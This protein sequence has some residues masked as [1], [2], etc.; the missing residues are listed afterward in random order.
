MTKHR[1]R[2]LRKRCG[3][4]RKNW[5]KCPHPWHFN[6]K[7]NGE[8]YR[9]S[10]DREVGHP[11]TSKTDA[12]KEADRIR[13]AIRE[14][15]FRQQHVVELVARSADTLTF[16]QFAE[17]WKA[18]RGGE[19]VRPKDNDYRIEKVKAF[20]LSGP[21]PTAFGDKPLSSITTDDI[22]AFRES[23]KA[24]GLSAVTVNHDLKLLRK[25]FNWGIR[26]GYMERTPFKVGSESAITLQREIPRDWRFESEDDEPKLL[27]AANP[28]LR[29][30]LIALLDTAARLGEILSLQWKDVNLERRELVIRA[31]SRRPG[32]GALCRFRLDSW[33]CWR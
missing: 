16:R 6:F 14:G 33:Q 11:I 10:L 31:E 23:R 30:V 13:T 5:P 9:F 17:I 29:L 21:Q 4:P 18:K 22:E 24:E 27:R 8:H 25:M 19:L 28:H 7:W 15:R 2:G 26:K 12:E 20:V 3:C 1:N 32:L